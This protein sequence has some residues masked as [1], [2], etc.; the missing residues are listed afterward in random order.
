MLG[1]CLV[2][3]WF[4]LDVSVP[5]LIEAEL[6]EAELKSSRLQVPG[7]RHPATRDTAHTKSQGA[8]LCIVMPAYL[9]LRKR[10]ER[11]QK[12]S[13]SGVNEYYI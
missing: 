11:G 12:S 13:V 2:Y 6:K 8:S 1:L 3:A 10:Q 9:T 5:S 4:I 7:S